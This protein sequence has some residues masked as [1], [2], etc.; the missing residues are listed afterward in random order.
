MK[1]LAKIRTDLAE[2]RTELAWQ[3]NR[4]SEMGVLIGVIGLGLLITRF[5]EAFWLVGV[6][7][8]LLGAVWLAI[9]ATRYFTQK[10]KMR[11]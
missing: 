11:C 5:Y 4:L 9:V 3:R 7:I 10:N 1:K 2:E 8:A 6:P